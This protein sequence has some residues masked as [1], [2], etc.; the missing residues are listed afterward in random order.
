MAFSTNPI[1]GK[2]HLH[3][4]SSD[5]IFYMT[6]IPGIAAPAAAR[7]TKFGHSIIGGWPLLAVKFHNMIVRRKKE[8]QSSLH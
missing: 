6:C 4:F 3:A 8:L 2:F 7:C 5:G 1:L